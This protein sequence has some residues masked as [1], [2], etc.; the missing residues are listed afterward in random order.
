MNPTRAAPPP[1]LVPT[2]RTKLLQTRVS[3]PC[4]QGWAYQLH[5]FSSN[6]TTG[7][8]ATF[9][10]EKKPLPRSLLLQDLAGEDVVLVDDDDDNDDDRGND[11]GVFGVGQAGTPGSRQS[12]QSEET[13]T[14][15]TSGN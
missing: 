15:S 1:P 11:D 4:I 2:N 7:F 13:H 9:F 10:G 14:N 8:R 12:V 5:S 6:P 3:N